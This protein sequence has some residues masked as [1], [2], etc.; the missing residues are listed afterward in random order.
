MPFETAK[1][2]VE[3]NMQYIGLNALRTQF[4]DFFESQNHT[5]LESF[6]LVPDHDPSLLLINAG[7]APLKPYFLGEKKMAH[8]RA[9]SAQRCVRTADIDNVGKTARHATFF[10]MLGN[11]SFGNYFK[12]EAI[13][14]AWTFLTEVIGLE[15][16][17]L[18]I[19]VYEEDD[20]A[21]RIWTEEV[22]VAPEKMLRLGKE[23]NFWELEQGPCGPCS[24]IHYDRGDAYGEGTNPTDNSDRFMEIWN[25]VF[26]QFNRQADGSYTPLAH[27]NIDT[28]MGLERLALVCEDKPNIFELDEFLPIR[29][30]IAQLSGK[31]YG[32][33]ERVNESF[34]VIIDHSKAITF[35]V[36][37]GV[38]PSNEGRGYVLRR[39]LRR[40]AR[41]GR[42]LGIE[43]EFLTQMIDE[44]ISV[45]RDVYPAL[46]EAKERIHTVV[47]REEQAFFQ[48]IDQGLSLLT[49][50]MDE[51]DRTETDVLD[52]A[53]VFRLYDTFGFPFDLTR[54]IAAER[55]KTVDEDDFNARMQE[56]RERSRTRRK[57]TSGW[58]ADEQVELSLNDATTFLGYET[59]EADGTILV[60]LR[61]GQEVDHLDAGERGIV[62][63][64]ETPFYAQGGGQV[65]DRGVLHQG[66]AEAEVVDVQKDKNEIILH[67]VEV[68][69]GT[70]HLNDIAHGMVDADRRNDTRRNH[71]ATHLLNQALHRVLG[72]HIKQ[73]GSYVDPERLRFDFTHFEALSDAQLE[74][75][76][77]IV[78]RAIFDSYPVQTEVLP[79]AQAM[80]EGAIGLFEDKY[81]DQVRVVSMGDFS[82]ELC[83]GTHVDNTSQV[84]MFCI[85]Q[86]QGVSSGVRRIEA[87]TGR[88][89]YRL[90]RDV[91]QQLTDEA[92]LLRVPRETI[93]TRTSALLDENREMKREIQSYESRMAEALSQKL[94][95]DVVDVAGVSV[96]ARRAD[97]KSM[98]ELKDLADALKKDR[99]EAVI[100]LASASGGKVFWVVS[101]SPQLNEKGLKAGDLVKQLAVQTGGNGGGRPNFATAGGKDATQIDPALASVRKW[102]EEKLS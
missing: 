65:A 72:D 62:V 37:D 70:L 30:A 33:S 83:G 17:R 79:L 12:T 16:E 41:H 48:T 32:D 91:D 66:A 25:L 47:S 61:D 34:R 100:A 13:H 22:G 84:Q 59:L 97:G 26:T 5:R 49:E 87:V 6:S 101:V 82:K 8:D 44:I 19:T 3:Q 2:E 85:L 86:E 76:E 73:A 7:M 94:A 31:E 58:E 56:Q 46:A 90:H 35:L 27:P 52:G 60:L 1:E 10:E 45:Y 14:W 53:R 29:R 55:N 43:G 36:W 75:V 57:E 67:T 4:L 28:G 39:L 54:E 50:L 78:N 99:Q 64:D 98:N 21:Y 81:H 23:D 88:G 92:E 42:L 18:W 9:T 93:Q 71:S 89:A 68:K 11:F 77:E 95:E 24:E 40:A 80:D 96:I 102:V 63:L 74:E 69:Q 51:A 15:S 20:E 38:V